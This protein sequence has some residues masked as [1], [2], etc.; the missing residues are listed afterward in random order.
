M[1]RIAEEKAVFI[2]FNDEASMRNTL[3]NN[4]EELAFHWKNSEGEEVTRR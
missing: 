4:P 2:E 1:Y 3:M